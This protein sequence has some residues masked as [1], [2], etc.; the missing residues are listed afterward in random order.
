MNTWQSSVRASALT[1]RLLLAVIIA[2]G[3]ALLGAGCGGASGP[4]S[5]SPT[6][7]PS[8]TGQ[9][10]PLPDSQSKG[11]A[12]LLAPGTYKAELGGKLPSGGRDTV[13]WYKVR[14]GAGQGVIGLKMTLPKGATYYE[15]ILMPNGKVM[16]KGSFAGPQFGME[17]PVATGLFYI[18]LE[19]VQGK[20]PYT[21]VLSVY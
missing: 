4:T 12:P 20:G 2:V 9:A 13:D 21:M 15:E 17:A 16:N 14:V 6:A 18:R 11:D 8:G 3:L 7:S 5:A 1:R 10:G 19:V